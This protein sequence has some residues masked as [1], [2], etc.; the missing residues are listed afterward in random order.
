MT[1]S[2]TSSARARVAAWRASVSNFCRVAASIF[3]GSPPAPDTCASRARSKTYWLYCWTVFWIWFW[4]ARCAAST[5]VPGPSTEATLLFRAMS[6]SSA[7]SLSRLFCS[8]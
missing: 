4:A 5:T 2:L 6:L 7:T 8:T 1:R 3:D